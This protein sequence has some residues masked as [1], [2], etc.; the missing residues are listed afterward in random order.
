M[1]LEIRKGDLS[2][3]RVAELL[4]R[5]LVQ[6][7]AETAPG[8]AHA[9]DHSGLQSPDISFWTVWDGL[10][11]VGMGAMK[12][13]DPEHYEVKSMHTVEGLRRKGI[14]STMLRHIIAAAKAAGA[15]RLSLETGS[16]DYFKPAVAFYHREGFDVCPPFDGYVED[17]NSIFM[18]RELV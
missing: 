9:L 4:D 12:Q 7:R 15:R 14:A 8:S 10:N 6:A 5:H 3:P 1:A 17:P 18:T 16:W 2:D 13:I 11:L